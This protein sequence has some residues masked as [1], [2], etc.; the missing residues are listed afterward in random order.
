[1]LDKSCV[2]Q[3]NYAYIVRLFRDDPESTISSSLTEL[4][5]D[6]V[7]ELRDTQRKRKHMSTVSDDCEI[8][9]KCKTADMFQFSNQGIWV[10]E[11]VIYATSAAL[12]VGVQAYCPPAMT[13]EY[14]P[15]ALTLKKIYGRGVRRATA[16]AMIVI[17]TTTCTFRVT[18]TSFVQTILWYYTGIVS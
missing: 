9:K 6:P 2:N 16:P 15:D 12:R 4:Y 1:M 18:L 8:H 7:E 11:L 10:A 17:W 14:E 3:N 13:N 5:V